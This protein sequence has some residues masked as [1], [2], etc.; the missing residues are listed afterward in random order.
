MNVIVFLAF[1]LLLLLCTCSGSP[2]GSQKGVPEQQDVRKEPKG[3]EVDADE[4][5]E[6]T[7]NK[8]AANIYCK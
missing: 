5:A 1:G 3:Q 7:K 4:A 2:V 6:E 8:C